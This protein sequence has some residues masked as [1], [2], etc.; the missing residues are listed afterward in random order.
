M[1]DVTW[2]K[3]N[4]FLPQL[5][6]ELF[7]EEAN[8][9]KVEKPA[10]VSQEMP[11]I[12]FSPTQAKSDYNFVIPMAEVVE[13]PS[14]QSGQVG[15]VS[16]YQSI[17]QSGQSS[18]NYVN[19]HQ[20]ISQ[21]Q[22]TGIEINN[23]IPDTSY[24]NPSDLRYSN[25]CQVYSQQCDTAAESLSHS[26]QGLLEGNTS[27]VK[28][29]FLS[30][31]NSPLHSIE[32]PIPIS[33]LVSGN[34]YPSLSKVP[35]N[36]VQS[37][38]PVFVQPTNIQTESEIYSDYVNDPY[39]L[40]LHAS[41]GTNPVTDQSPVQEEKAPVMNVADPDSVQ[42]LGVSNMFQSS[43]YFRN[44]SGVIPPGSEVFFGGP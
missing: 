25:Q 24:V 39:N 44:D 23:P 3:I 35:P 20:L 1:W 8:R 37:F 29:S 40:T 12:A 6:E 42:K 28:N 36:I 15:G 17:D 43:N 19:S 26:S 22:T 13:M 11:Q 32:P 31:Q 5:K 33:H 38:A 27:P 4:L 41:I 7:R 30:N 21:Y 14:Q 18:E 9:V 16:N 34:Q 10:N 2:N